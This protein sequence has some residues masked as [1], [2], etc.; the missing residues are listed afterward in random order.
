MLIHSY[1]GRRMGR[2]KRMIWSH[3]SIYDCN[4]VGAEV[5]ASSMIRVRVTLQWY[6][7]LHLC[8]EAL[9]GITLC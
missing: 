1:R 5:H 4:R 8:K 2:R 7:V 3:V 6:L 9:Y